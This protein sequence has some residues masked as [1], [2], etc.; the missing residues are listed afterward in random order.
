LVLALVCRAGAYGQAGTPAAG[1][2]VAVSCSVA[3]EAFLHDIRDDFRR[4]SGHDLGISCALAASVLDRINAGGTFDIVILPPAMIDGLAAKGRAASATRTM[5]G[6]SP[7][8]LAQSAGRPARPTQT[9]DEL[10]AVLDQSPSIA[11]AR[12]GLSGVFFTNL[13]KQW[14]L[15]VSFA[16]KL[17]PRDTGLDVTAAVTRGEADLGVLPMSEIVSV[18]GLEVAGV[19]PAALGGFVVMEAA[20]SSDKANRAPVT[21]FA[22]FL[23][24]PE[25]IAALK[26]SG[27]ERADAPRR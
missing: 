27:F 23:S 22:S 11:F 25:S 1:E 16:S 17:R 3:V 6:R 20:A 8:A 9:V 18:Q 14:Q 26:K 7:V 5:I 2:T 15:T 19:F 24:T 10:R 12:Q 21:A 4:S 13:L